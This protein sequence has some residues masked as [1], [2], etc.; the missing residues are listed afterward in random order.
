M[1]DNKRIFIATSATIVAIDKSTGRELWKTELSG[2]I[3]GG[4]DLTSM[5]FDDIN[6]YAHAKGELFC[7]SQ[8]NGRILWRNGL[9]G[10]G[11][12]ACIIGVPGF[13]ES[14]QYHTAAVVASRQRDSAAGTHHAGT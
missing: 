12:R 7:L 11:Y 5:A 13:P 3:L 14:N 8:S 1:N 4:M 6:I 2:S 10:L 9:T